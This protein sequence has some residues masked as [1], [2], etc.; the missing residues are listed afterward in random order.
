MR[1]G[2]ALK[3][4]AAADFEAEVENDERAYRD[5]PSCAIVRS[6]FYTGTALIM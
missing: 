3:N 4:E 5:A 1:C 6:E 2:Y